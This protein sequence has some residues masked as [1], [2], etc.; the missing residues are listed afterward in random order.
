VKYLIVNAD[1]FGASRGINR[2]IGELCERGVVT[3]ASLMVGMPAARHAAEL[4]KRTPSLGVGLHAMLTDED[5]TELVDFDD[6]D[7]CSK[8]IERQ[9]RLFT[10]QVG[11]LPTHLDSHRNVHRDPRLTPVF[12]EIAGRY[13][14]PLREHSPVRYFSSFYGQWDDGESHPE[15]I[16]IENLLRMLERELYDGVTE[17][18]CHPGYC[19]DD[20][21]SSYDQEREVELHTL[22]DP[23]LRAFLRANRVQLVDFRHLR[24]A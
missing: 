7:R 21:Q 5:G 8:A 6:A 11:K 15:H 22:S 4:A 12:K 3:S 1:D 24:A 19:G 9:I 10:T 14:L 20:F 2:A 16:S 17:L 23:K 13:R 18:S